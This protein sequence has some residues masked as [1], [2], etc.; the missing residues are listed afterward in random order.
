MGVFSRLSRSSAVWKSDVATSLVRPPPRSVKIV[1]STPTY[2]G[3]PSHSSVF[4]MRWFGTISRYRPPN[5][6]GSPRDPGT[7]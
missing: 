1:V 6:W 4:T 3:M 2:P 5:A 7:T